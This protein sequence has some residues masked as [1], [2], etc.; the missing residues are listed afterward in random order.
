MTP[1]ADDFLIIKIGGALLA[2]PDLLAETLSAI[3]NVARRRRVVVIP[4]GGPFADAVR[5]IDQT[6]GLSDDSAHWMAILGMD[7]YAFLLAERLAEGIVVHTR[8][9]IAA[10]LSAS[11][12]PVLAP[13]RW[14]RAEDPLPH[15]WAVT[16][17]SI[18][19]WFAG[20]LGAAHLLLIK[21]PNAEGPLVDAYFTRALPPDV[22]LSTVA[23]GLPLHS[24]LEA[25]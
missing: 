21:H 10:A 2:S 22:Q 5:A 12:V 16:S 13:S 25:C 24:A 20:E 15:S 11:L 6:I 18:A 23:A 17:D 3:D 19:A 14:L 4:G 1:S 8:E 7:Q 9:D